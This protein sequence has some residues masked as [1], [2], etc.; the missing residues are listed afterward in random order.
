MTS[1]SGFSAGMQSQNISID[2]KQHFCVLC[3]G[4][5]LTCSHKKEASDATV[6]DNNGVE[7]SPGA[8]GTL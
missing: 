8:T 4:G 1:G 5:N 3:S 6:G 7:M 2:R